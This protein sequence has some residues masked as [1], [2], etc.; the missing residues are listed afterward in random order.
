MKIKVKYVGGQQAPY[1]VKFS[2]R[3]ASIVYQNLDEYLDDIKQEISEEMEM[4]E[5]KYL[6]KQELKNKKNTK[7]RNS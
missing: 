4:Q 3:K 7:S 2:D 1:Q 6:E 5:K